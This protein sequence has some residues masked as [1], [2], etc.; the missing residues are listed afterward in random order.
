MHL[1]TY[2]SLARGPSTRPGTR[3][4]GG[5]GTRPIILSIPSV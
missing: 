5:R 2:L 4:E 1:C 3:R